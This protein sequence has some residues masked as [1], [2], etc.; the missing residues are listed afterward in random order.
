MTGPPDPPQQNRSTALEEE[1][2]G[3]G[4]RDILELRDSASCLQKIIACLR[5]AARSLSPAR[6]PGA[7]AD[8][9]SRHRFDSIIFGDDD[10]VF[11]PH[12]FLLDMAEVA[13]PHLLIGQLSW[14]GYWDQLT[15]RH[16]GFANTPGEVTQAL[17]APPKHAYLNSSI[18][19]FIFPIGMWMGLGAALAQHLAIAVNAEPAL[20]KLQADLKHR[21]VSLL[22]FCG[23]ACGWAHAYPFP[24]AHAHGPFASVLEEAGSHSSP[25][26]HLF[27]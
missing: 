6:E 9:Q 25:H 22:L 16:R 11:H 20:V 27:V 23:C 8:A 1:L 5:H 13:D 3:A 14:A 26:L 7:S 17:M 4:Q 10:A 21:C 15:Q 18:G 12:R 2:A 24:Q 19:P